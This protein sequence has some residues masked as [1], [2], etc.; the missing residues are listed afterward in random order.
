VLSVFILNENG[1]KVF[2]TLLAASTYV[3]ISLFSSVASL[4]QRA[5]EVMMQALYVHPDRQRTHFAVTNKQ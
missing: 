1:V 3:S 5:Q 4:S 2:S